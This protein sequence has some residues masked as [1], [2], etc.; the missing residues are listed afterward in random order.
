MP[1]VVIRSTPILRD[2]ER[3]DRRTEEEFADVIP[4][5]RERVGD[6]I[7]APSCR[8]LHERYVEAVV[9]GRGQRR[10]LTVVPVAGIRPASVVRAGGD[11][12]RGV[13]IDRDNQAHA[14]HVL[15]ADAHR[16]A[17]AELLLEL[18]A[19]L[20][21]VRVPHV[22]IHCGQVRQGNGRHWGAQDIRECGRARL[23]GRQADADLTQAGKV[24]R[25]SRRQQ[26]VCE[27]AK[28]HAIVEQSRAPANERASRFGRRPHEPD[29]RRDVVPVG[30]DRLQE[31]EIVA[32]AGVHRDAGA[33]F[34]LVLRVHSNVRIGLRYDG[35]AESLR[36][37][38]VVVDARQEIR[39]RRKGVRAADRPRKRD[40]V[41]VVQ[42]VDAGTDRVRSGLMRQVVD[43]LVHPVLPA[44]G[45]ARKRPERRDALDAHRR[46]HHIG[47]RRFQIAVR[48]L[49][50][51][52]VDR[53]RGQAQ[54]IAEGDR[55][56]AVVQGRRRAG[57]AQSSG[58]AGV[59]R[60]GAVLAVANADVIATRRMVLHL[61]EH[62]RPIHW[63]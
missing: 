46:S 60:R 58:A 34:P 26:R 45:T 37:A 61:E 20:T 1:L 57:R 9:G 7:V 10:I 5:L 49:R 23:R 55:A 8:P 44:G 53:P 3:I 33:G 13:V 18:D 50:P 12:R 4:R 56:I 54:R 2:I 39:Q 11:A 38:G 31:L 35:C 16:A 36:E 52:L 24:Y 22:G 32:D 30:M 21:G 27:R 48:K 51:R 14:A 19:R 6:A 47:R 17:P 43:E 63:I 15:I 25:I 28:R 40:R 29:A 62:S 42:N 41:V 59:G